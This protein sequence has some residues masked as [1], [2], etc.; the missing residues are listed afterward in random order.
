MA[1]SVTQTALESIQTAIVAGIG[2]DSGA[3]HEIVTA[4]IVIAKLPWIEA[5]SQLPG[6]VLTPVPEIEKPATN[7]SDDIGYGVQVTIAQPSNRNLT[8]DADRMFYWR[9][10]I[11]GLFR[12]KRVSGVSASYN[13]LIEPKPVIDPAAFSNLFDATAF[14]VR[15][16]TRKQRPA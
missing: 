2:T 16:W 8:S 7:A 4:H 1:A 11:M 3:T 15:V 12:H 13:T 10:T 9:E 6:V 5:D 14:V